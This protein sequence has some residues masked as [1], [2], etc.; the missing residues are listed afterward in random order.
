MD[1]IGRKIMQLERKIEL[2]NLVET[3]IGETRGIIW[4]PAH[5][6]TV[7]TGSNAFGPWTANFTSNNIDMRVITFDGSTQEFANFTDV[8]PSN[9]DGGTV[10]FQ[11]YWTGVTGTGT[12]NWK[13]SARAYADSDAIDQA[14]G[15][16]VAVT[17]TIITNDDLHI[18]PESGAVTIAGSPAANQL[19]QWRISRG[20]GADSNNTDQRLIGYRI[21]YKKAVN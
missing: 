1:E 21:Y 20:A 17:D 10:T 13:L 18:S 9:Y 5:F 3:T 12:V 15:S 14:T 7:E 2:L 11:A 6:M 16:E 19:V 8:L 4:I